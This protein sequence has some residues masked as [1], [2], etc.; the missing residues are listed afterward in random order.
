MEWGGRVSGVGGGGVFVVRE[1]HPPLKGI[2]VSTY[3]SVSQPFLPRDPK[4][5]L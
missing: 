1:V 4:C 2:V 3:T 5:R